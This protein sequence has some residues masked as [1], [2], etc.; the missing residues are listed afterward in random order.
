MNILLIDEQLLKM[1]MSYETVSEIQSKDGVYVYRVRSSN[2]V[3]VL[4]YFEK[5]DYRREINN[6]LV[7]QEL[8]I[9]TI[10]LIAYTDKSILMLDIKENG[11]YRLGTPKDMND[12]EIYTPLA[13]WYKILHEK[14][15]DYVKSY[16]NDMYMET[17][18]ITDINIAFIKSKTHTEDNQVWT[19]IEQNLNCLYSLINK[20]EKTLTYNDFYYT[21]MVVAKD[22]SKAFMFDYNLLGKG[23]AASDIRNVTWGLDDCAKK[24]FLNAYGKCNEDEILLDNVT[25]PIISLYFASCRDFFPQWGHKELELVKNGYLLECTKK[26]FR[27]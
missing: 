14:G 2:E 24:A 20:V 8:D 19:I 22:K 26:L 27:I 16:G 15:K 1:N 13:E 18:C 23:Y 3:Y 5:E 11:E 17:D 7:L 9:P 21:N 10:P 25:S 4:K 12:A 6:Y